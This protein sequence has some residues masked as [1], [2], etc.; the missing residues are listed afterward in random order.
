[1]EKPLLTINGIDIFKIKQYGTNTFVLKKGF[2]TIGNFY[3]LK[4]AEKFA[5]K[6]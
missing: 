2:A 6:S 1:M 5:K 3:T 4:E